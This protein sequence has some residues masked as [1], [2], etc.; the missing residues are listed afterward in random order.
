MS[1]YAQVKNGIVQEVVSA[2]S[3][4]IEAQQNSS[5]WVKTSYNT[6]GGVHYG[7]DGNPD[8]GEQVGYNYAGIGMLWDGT[9][10]YAQRPYPS[11]T[12]NK[13]TYQWEAPTPM[14]IDGNVYVWD[15]TTKTWIEIKLIN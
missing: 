2:E 5:E 14:P 8:G 9:G 12:L 1:H 4:W 15:E 13:D 11:W 3:A 10:F 6:R 7:K